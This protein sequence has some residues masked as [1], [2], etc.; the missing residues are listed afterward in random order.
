M[1]KID[2]I[3]INR[4]LGL[5]NDK[6]TVIN[7]DIA[8]LKIY[9]QLEKQKN[10]ITAYNKMHGN[11]IKGFSANSH[12]YTRD[13]NVYSISELLFKELLEQNNINGFIHEHKI[14][15]NDL[16]MHKHFY[17]LD[18]YFPSLKIA[19]EINPLFHYTYA[20]VAIR[21]KIRTSLLKRKHNIKVLDV[22]VRFRTKK[23]II[24]TYLDTKSANNAINE[25]KAQ[26]L[27][28]PHKETLN[29]YMS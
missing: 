10:A 9:S 24:Q 25:I 20:N 6:I 14:S 27:N 15:V 17:H 26:L 28:K 1:L 13:K 7:E 21:D 16:I 4:Y 12:N 19:I 22:I 29:A 3:R 23:G 8:M 18:F 5:S 11:K 2:S